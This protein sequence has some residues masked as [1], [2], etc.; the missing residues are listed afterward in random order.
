MKMSNKGYCCN[1]RQGVIAIGLTTVA[2]SVLSM[3]FSV[4]TLK[5]ISDSGPVRDKFME[6][7]KR[8]QGGVVEKLMGFQLEKLPTFKIIEKV[9]CGVCGELGLSALMLIVAACYADTILTKRSRMLLP[10]CIFSFIAANIWFIGRCVWI[11]RNIE[12]D[13]I[14]L[15]KYV[16]LI[17]SVVWI[18][19]NL[20]IGA[21]YQRL[22]RNQDNISVIIIDDVEKAPQAVP[23]R[24]LEES[25]ENL[26]TQ[27]IT[28][29]TKSEG[30]AAMNGGFMY[31]EA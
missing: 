31:S 11:L 4:M 14:F 10:V 18:Y 13:G 7:R 12:N 20:I 3:T 30:F 29:Q 27:T 22:D 21:F 8:E 9:N 17:S 16:S 24:Q 23:Y 6:E 15:I 25:E 19:F 26:R 2:F 1:L 5:T 28:L